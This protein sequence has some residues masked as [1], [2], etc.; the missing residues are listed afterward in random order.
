MTWTLVLLHCNGLFYGAISDNRRFHLLLIWYRVNFVVLVLTI[1][2]NDS[3]ENQK[4]GSNVSLEYY[5]PSS[6]P[7][8]WG[9][10]NVLPE[11]QRALRKFLVTFNCLTRDQALI[12]DARARGLT[13]A[14]A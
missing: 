10:S 2:C 3:C 13:C 9:G 8:R 11:E 12:S 14:V 5:Y 4:G 1:S 6:K 7:K